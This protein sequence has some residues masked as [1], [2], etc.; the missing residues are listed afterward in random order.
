MIAIDTNVLI[1]FLV[2]DQA[3]QAAAARTLLQGLTP[4]QP[5]FI[6]REVA[7]EVAW[8]L[9]RSY[10]FPREQIAETL[11]DLLASNDLEFEAADDVAHAAFR[12]AQGGPGFSDLMILAAATR[13]G[14]APLYTFDRRLSRAEGAKLLGAG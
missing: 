8:V 11:Q 3:E 1:R 12:Y 13:A 14:A 5:G 4:E 2:R 10:G 7:T 6:C 9:E